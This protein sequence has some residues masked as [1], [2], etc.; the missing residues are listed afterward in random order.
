MNSILIIVLTD[1]RI[2]WSVVSTPDE[3]HSCSLVFGIYTADNV[4]LY[5]S[6]LLTNRSKSSLTIL[7]C[8]RSIANFSEVAGCSRSTKR[9]KFSTAAQLNIFNPQLA[10]YILTSHKIPFYVRYVR[11]CFFSC[12]KIKHLVT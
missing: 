9:N 4:L 7:F 12:L 1:L 6:L 5:K 11:S 3:L 10:D 2:R 8:S